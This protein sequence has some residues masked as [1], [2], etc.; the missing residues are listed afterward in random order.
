MSEAFKILHV[1]DE[2][3]MELLV[4]QKYR[5]EIRK[6]IYDFYFAQNGEQAL[7]ILK[8]HEDIY[9]VL[10]DINMPVMDGLQLL[11]EIQQLNRPLI[12][13]IMV[14][15]YGDMHNIRTAMNRGAFDFINKPIDF[16]DFTATVEKARVEIEKALDF[17]KKE[18]MFRAVA[19]DLSAAGKIQAA[20]LPKLHGQFKDY[21][22]LQVASY[23]KPAKWGGGDF[24]DV[25]EIEKNRIGI[26]MADVSGKGLQAAAF[27][28][29]SRTAVRIF[30]SIYRK[31]SEVLNAANN[32]LTMDNDASM[33]VTLF[34]G[35]LNLE[36]NTFDYCNAGHNPPYLLQ[37]GTV[38]PVPPTGNIALGIMPDMPFSDKSIRLNSGDK[39]FLFTDGVSESMN[40]NNEEFDES[41]IVA[42]LQQTTESDVMEIVNSM[43]NVLRNHQGKAEQHDDITMLCVGLQNA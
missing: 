3:D 2:P 11:H 12:K 25:F 30:S 16:D 40:E 10:S 7:T 27:M 22:Q 42:Q 29:L 41:N 34:Y 39:I 28:F 23:I 8:E 38:A 35:V 18:K 6:G 21:A 37:N 15:A 9:L 26:I 4:R 24:Y 1:D 36:T 5:R 20:M 32:Y 17:R 14:S 31:P 33:F 13:V 19:E 43:T